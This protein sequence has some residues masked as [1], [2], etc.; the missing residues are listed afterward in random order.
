M[1][2]QPCCT[3]AINVPVERRDVSDPQILGWLPGWSI[4]KGGQ[5][6]GPEGRVGVSST[7]LVD[8]R[9]LLNVVPRNPF[10]T[11]YRS[12]STSSQQLVI[13]KIED[14]DC[15]GDGDGNICSK[16]L[17]GVELD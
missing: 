7:T 8:W 5:L 11:Y 10:S 1:F 16:I 3:V 6:R 17:K 13:S 4:S 12:L 2:N 15:D 9:F 14:G